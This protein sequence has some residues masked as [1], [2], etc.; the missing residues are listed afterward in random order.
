MNE[1]GNRDN[2]EQYKVAQ[3]K[4]VGELAI[5]VGKLSEQVKVRQNKQ[6]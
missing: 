4:L 6:K 3:E 2:F 5:A 1:I